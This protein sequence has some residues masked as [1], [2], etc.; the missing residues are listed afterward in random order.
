MIPLASTTL[1]KR[2]ARAHDALEA[3]LA[4]E[5]VELDEFGKVATDDV[6]SFEATGAELRDRASAPRLTAD[7]RRA[8]AELA[9]R[10]LNRG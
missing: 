9:R 7:A 10:K 2:V 3:D 8:V 6:E 1:T 5:V 4:D